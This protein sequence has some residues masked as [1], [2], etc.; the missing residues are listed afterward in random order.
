MLTAKSSPSIELKSNGKLRAGLCQ[1]QN[2]DCRRW[3]DVVA[4]LQVA[5]WHSQPV[6]LDKFAP[7]VR[8]REASAHGS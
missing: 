4:R 8:L 1:S 6:K 2:V 7:R 5:S 3:G